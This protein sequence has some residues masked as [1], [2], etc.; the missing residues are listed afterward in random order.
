MTTRSRRARSSSSVIASSGAGCDERGDVL[1]LIAAAYDLDRQRDFR[2][3]IE[4]ANC[5]CG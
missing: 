3:I 2:E 4:I 1:A 5:D